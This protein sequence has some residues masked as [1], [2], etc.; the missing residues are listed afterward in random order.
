MSGGRSCLSCGGE[1]SPGEHPSFCFCQQAA[2]QAAAARRAPV[3]SPADRTLQPAELRAIIEAR[4][5]LYARDFPP[6]ASPAAFAEAL[7]RRG[8]P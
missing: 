5:I 6:V 7:W 3:S 8:A 2:R 1:L 4:D